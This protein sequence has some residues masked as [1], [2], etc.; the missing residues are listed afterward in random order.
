[1]DYI[2]YVFQQSVKYLLV[3]ILPCSL[4]STDLETIPLNE[5]PKIESPK[6]KASVHIR[7]E[8]SLCNLLHYTSNFIPKTYIILDLYILTCQITLSWHISFAEANHTK[9]N[10]YYG[11]GQVPENGC[12]K[13]LVW[14]SW[15]SDKRHNI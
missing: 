3:E 14:N 6:P 15:R 2:V 9:Q 8:H 7:Y 10:E 5:G 12:I 4:E 13:V 1:M 11:S